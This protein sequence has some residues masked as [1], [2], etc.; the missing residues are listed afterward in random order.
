MGLWIG[1]SVATLF[2]SVETLTILSVWV[3]NWIRA[4]RPKK[5]IPP[6]K[7][8]VVSPSLTYQIDSTTNSTI[9]GI[10]KGSMLAVPHGSLGTSESHLSSKLLHVH[11]EGDA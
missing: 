9:S 10:R 5:V 8:S 1:V 2:E 6:A 4:R 7:T 11:F 3:Y